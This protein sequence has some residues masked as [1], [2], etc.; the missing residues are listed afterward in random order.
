MFKFVILGII[1]IVVF[2]SFYITV[3]KKILKPMKD[4]PTQND[5]KTNI[6]KNPET[7]KEG[8]K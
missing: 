7:T 8:T 4:E 2:L 6:I 1:F 5:V 3:W